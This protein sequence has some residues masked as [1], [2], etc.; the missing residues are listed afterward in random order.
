[1]SVPIC[2]DCGG[3]VYSVSTAYGGCLQVECRTLSHPFEGCGAK[4]RPRQTNSEAWESYNI[5][6]RAAA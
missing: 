4:W 3:S 2:P 6:E 1:M 5:D